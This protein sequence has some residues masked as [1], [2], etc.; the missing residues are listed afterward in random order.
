MVHRFELATLHVVRRTLATAHGYYVTPGNVAGIHRGAPG[1]NT[2][3]GRPVVGV[4]AAPGGR[5]G[6][7]G[8]A[9]GVGGVI[10]GREKA[11]IHAKVPTLRF[12]A[13]S[14]EALQ[15][16]VHIAYTRVY[17]SN[18]RENHLIGVPL[19]NGASWNGRWRI[20][21]VSCRIAKFPSSVLA[22]FGL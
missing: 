9:A 12:A 1:V 3:V 2:V 7:K 15:P 13:A 18:V 4:V 5:V 17:T 19:E 11:R 10:Y 14:H 16:L 20:Y 8:R 21:R 6:V 22:N